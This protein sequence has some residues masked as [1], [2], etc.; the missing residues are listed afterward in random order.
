MV[1]R[2]TLSMQEVFRLSLGVSFSPLWELLV[3]SFRRRW[4]HLRVKVD[5][6][7]Q[8]GYFAIADLETCFVS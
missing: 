7:K 6:Q 3:S 8:G 2:L 5:G 4:F 1:M